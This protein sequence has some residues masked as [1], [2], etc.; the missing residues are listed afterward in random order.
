MNGVLNKIQTIAG[1][2]KVRQAS[3]L[4]IS[5]SI[6]VLVGIGVSVLNTRLL[7]PEQYGDFKFLQ[8]LFNFAV[9]FVTLGLFYSGGRLIAIEKVRLG[10]RRIVGGI[11]ILA[12]CMSIA[13]FILFFIFSF[14]E[15]NIFDNELGWYVRVL[16][17]FLFIFP[18]QLGLDNLLQGSNRIYQLSAF[19]LGPKV[20]YL[21]GILAYSYF[22]PFNLNHALIFHFGSLGAIILMSLLSLKPDFSVLSKSLQRIFQENRSYGFQVFLGAVA[23]LASAQLGGLAIG[24]FID[25]TN[26]GFFALAITASQPLAMIPNSIGTTFFRDFTGMARIPKKVFITTILISLISLAV[27]LLVIKQLVIFLYT[28][29]YLAVVPIAYYVSVGSI[30][31]GLGDFFNRFLAAQGRG[32]EMRNTNIIIGL[33]N[34]L[35]Y[36]FLTWWIGVQGAAIT[37][38]LAGLTYALVM[39]LYYLKLTRN[40]GNEER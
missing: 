37:K 12:L 22:F 3:V 35:G 15:E 33:S 18:F 19:R 32:K 30:L 27:F 7:G 20:L 24:Y 16:S 25:N 29:E 6:G 21:L 40:R 2:K 28:E 38:L 9:T 11:S 34:I 10:Q 39:A 36:I 8:S 4:Y 1:K 31:H 13:L 17:P 5:L 26:V 23:G 14:F